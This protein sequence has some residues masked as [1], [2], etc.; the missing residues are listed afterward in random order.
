MKKLFMAAVLLA[1]SAL[2]AYTQTNPNVH[3]DQSR[4]MEKQAGHVFD[5]WWGHITGIAGMNTV[6]ANALVEGDN[7]LYMGSGAKYFDVNIYSDGP[8]GYFPGAWWEHI[9]GDYAYTSGPWWLYFDFY[10]GPGD[11]YYDFHYTDD[12][13]D[14][15]VSFHFVT[16]NA[17]PPEN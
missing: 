6:Y 13:G 15:T 16:T 10:N 3:N 5:Q 9:S 12:T 8:Q 17:N 4:T 11:A 2:T 7:L 1:A 14:H